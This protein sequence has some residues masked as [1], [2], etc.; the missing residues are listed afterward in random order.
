MLYNRTATKINRTATKEPLIWRW[1]RKQ[2]RKNGDKT[3]AFPLLI[4]VITT[5]T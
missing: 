3:L 4:Q 5:V 2:F 1:Y